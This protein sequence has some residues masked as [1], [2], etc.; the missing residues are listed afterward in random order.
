MGK[1][2]YTACLTMSCRILSRFECPRSSIQEVLGT[3]WSILSKCALPISRC[4]RKRC[5]RPCIRE[6]TP[7]CCSFRNNRCAVSHL[8]LDFRTKPPFYCS[9]PRAKCAV[10]GHLRF[11]MI[12][13]HSMPKFPQLNRMQP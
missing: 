5:L 13:A 8:H 3:L 4:G 6:P 1:V 2:T 9:F 11:L 10:N 7:P 12:G